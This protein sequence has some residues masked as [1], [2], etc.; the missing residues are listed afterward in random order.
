[1]MIISFYR[2]WAFIIGLFLTEGAFHQIHF[3]K[4]QIAEPMASQKLSM[5]EAYLIMSNMN[6]STTSVFLGNALICEGCDL[7]EMAMVAPNSNITLI[8]NTQYA[9]EFE[10]RSLSF[11]TSLQC[12]FPS[13]KFAE[14]GT[15]LFEV[16]QSEE[17]VNQP[18][19]I[20]QIGES[21]D[22]WSPVIVGLV[23]WVV[24]I[25]IIQLCYHS[26]RS[27]Y[28]DQ[29][30]ANILRKRL[31]KDNFET[32]PLV[33]P[34]PSSENLKQAKHNSSLHSEADES[35]VNIVESD[36]N[37][38]LGKPNHQSKKNIDPNSVIPKRFQA[39]DTFRGLSL[40]VMIFVN[41][42]GMFI[43]YRMVCLISI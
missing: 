20:I 42:G 15:Y 34:I 4:S 24:F 37:L 43:F 21:S 33:N 36:D 13:Y 6:N 40:M 25:A 22:Y 18:C 28:F 29:F 3:L 26:Y 30:V 5:D 35:T 27:R 38:L 10:V 9:Y 19:S 14:H 41:Y 7:E 31:I 1:M 2:I 8:I 23:M 32:M 16:I 17:T 12:H 11:N 39:L